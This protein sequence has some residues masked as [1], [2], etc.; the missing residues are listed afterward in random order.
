MMFV[1]FCPLIPEVDLFT[2]LPLSMIVHDLG[3]CILQD[4]NLNPL[5]SSENSKMK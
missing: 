4:T 3:T 2:S 5:K 1:V